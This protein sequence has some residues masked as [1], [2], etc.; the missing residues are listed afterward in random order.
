MIS[1]ADI[2]RSRILIVD[3]MKA[4]VVLL[5]KILSG[6]GYSSVESTTNPLEV[7]EL[8]HKNRYDLI[9][10][11]LSMPVMNGFAV[12]EGLKKVEG[13]GYLPVLV[14]TAQPDQKLHAL[15]AGAR[16][17]VSKPF[18]VAEVLV[19]A[20]KILEIRL[21]NRETKTLY[22]R[23]LAEKKV[24]ERLL[25]NVLPSSIVERLRMRPEDAVENLPDIIADRFAEVTVLFAD[26]VGFTKFSETVSPEAL[27]DILNDLFT[28]FDDIADQRGL[29]KIKTI[30]D[31]YMAAAGIPVPTADHA[32][33]AAHMALD[34]IEALKR[35]NLRRR[36]NLQ[37]RIGIGS[38][39]VVA[40]VIG[41]RK[42]RYDVWGDVVNTASR[43]ESHGVPGRI[44]LTEAT[45]Q[46]LS[47]AFELEE[48][49][50]IDVRGKGEMLTWFLNSRTAIPVS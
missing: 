5:D 35:F 21:L 50:A 22:E 14:L 38:G 12:M 4:N 1:Q 46:R 31:C 36:I 27:V 26:I 42:F 39:E 47:E 30:G 24:S 11:D 44:Q 28:R 10:L 19:R 41:R 18:D 37:V 9:L 33:R 34:M 45:R 6:A 17:F 48:R 8:H 2:L 40:G 7:C 20:Q 49:G 13:E 29:E 23:I 16:D 32:S 25:H 3:D 43:M 15:N